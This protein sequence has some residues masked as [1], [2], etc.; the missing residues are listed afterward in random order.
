M[1]Y[2]LIKTTVNVKTHAIHQTIDICNNDE[3]LTRYWKN[4]SSENNM[5]CAGTGDKINDVKYYT[6]SGKI[7]NSD[8]IISIMQYT[9]NY[10]P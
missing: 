2:K 7:K 4:V 1:K 9:L 10:L 5:L 6:Q 3:E 8:Y